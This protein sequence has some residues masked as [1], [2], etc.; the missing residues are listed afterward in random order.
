MSVF[1]AD[2]ALDLIQKVKKYSMHDIAYKIK[3]PTLVL[4]GDKDR[5]FAGQAAKLMA[6]LNVQKNTF[7]LQVRK[8]QKIIVI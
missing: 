4:A 8:A 7:Y 1:S 2:S 6:Y 5:S 3:C